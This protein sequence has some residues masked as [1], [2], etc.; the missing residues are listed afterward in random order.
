MTWTQQQTTDEANFDD[1]EDEDLFDNSFDNEGADAEFPDQQ[2]E[3]E[4]EEQDPFANSFMNIRTPPDIATRRP[5]T[6]PRSPNSPFNPN[7]YRNKDI[8]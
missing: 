2:N 5:L 4:N 8:F 1:D 6:R 7:L 3:S